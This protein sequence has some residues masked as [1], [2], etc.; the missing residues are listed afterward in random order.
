MDTW[1]HHIPKKMLLKSDGFASNLASPARDSSL[2]EYCARSEISYDDLSIPVS[3]DTFIKYGIDFQRRFVPNLDERCVVG[4]EA[5]QHGFRIELDGG[6]TLEARR[7]VVA[8]GITH[9]DYTPEPLAALAGELVSHSSA[10]SDLEKFKNL[11][12]NY[13]RGRCIR[14]RF[15]RVVGGSWARVSLVARRPVI[16]FG[17]PPGP[18]GRGTWD[19]LRHPQSG[20]GPGLRSRMACEF[21]HLFR[22]LPASLRMEIVRRHLGP[23]SPWYQRPRVIGKISTHLGQKIISSEI[24]NGRVHLRL[25]A[26]DGVL[27]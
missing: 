2:A 19:K 11:D 17:A 27:Q 13:N 16:R 25:G 18:R 14:C 15:G 8:A 7:V 1:R 12:V 6:E 20:L 10:H 22:Y 21:P 5:N 26:L 23:A 3:L 9:F 24:N 4:V